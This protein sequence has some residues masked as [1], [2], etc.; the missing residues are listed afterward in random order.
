[1]KSKDKIQILVVDDDPYFLR[2][3]SRML[4]SAGYEVI[5][6]VTGKDCLLKAQENELDLAFLDVMLP[7]TN[8]LSLMPELQ[9]I[10]PNMSIVVMTAHGDMEIVIQALRLGAVDFL[11]KPIQLLELEAVLEKTLRFSTMRQESRRLRMTIRSI[12]H[13]NELRG[14]NRSFVGISSASHRIR[15]QIQQV[16]EAECDTILITGETGTGKEVLARAIHFLASS[17]ENPFIAVSCPAIPGSLVESELFGHT[18]GAFTGATEDRAGHFEMADGGTLFL[19]EI[20]DLSASAQAKL[21]RVLE[22]RSLTRVGSSKEISVNVR[23]ISATNAPLEELVEAGK[24]RSDL[25]YRLNVFKIYIPPLRE[26]PADIL[27]LAEH[28][29]SSYAAQRGLS[30]DGLSPEAQER[31]LNYGFPGNARELRNMIERAAILCRSGQI[32]SED[33]SLPVSRKEDNLSP[34]TEFHKG[35]ENEERRRI[36][37]ALEEARWNRS[38]AAKILGISYSKLRYRMQKHNIS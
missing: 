16:V 8:G 1:M 30:F 21:L 18:K 25:F 11:K 4:R 33:L 19:D 34:S 14:Q 24:F 27:S 17:D 37:N 5:E 23:V 15:K 13:T 32:K 20:G 3:I 7:D 26:R 6:A 22:T 36:L 35:G 38:N 9:K 28:F 2:G 29:L 12:Q 31:L 10:R